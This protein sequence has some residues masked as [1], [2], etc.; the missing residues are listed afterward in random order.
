[1]MFELV[2]VL[3]DVFQTWVERCVNFYERNAGA[4]RKFYLH[5]KDHLSVTE[6][7]EAVQRHIIIVNIIFLLNKQ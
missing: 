7:G 5:A 3:I 1:M 6:L 4:A 2:F